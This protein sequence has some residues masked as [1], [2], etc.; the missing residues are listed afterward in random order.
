MTE[1]LIS[2]QGAS[3][4]STA[5]SRPPKNFLR[6]F[7]GVIFDPAKSFP[8]I[9]AI[10]SW[11]PILLVI[12]LLSGGFEQAYHS[13][14]I[15]M[16]IQ[17]LEARAGDNPQQMQGVMAFYQNAAITRPLFF[18]STALF[19]IVFLL[20]ITILSFF[21]C[22]VLF[23]GTARFKQVWVVSLWAYII[24]LVGMLVKTLLVIAKN[25][26]EAGLNFGLIFSENLVGPKLHGFFGA[27]DIFGIWH[28]IVM[29][30]G[31]AILY[32]FTIKKGI[33]ISFFI[34]LLMTLVG[35]V[36]AYVSA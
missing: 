7:F 9:I 21:V 14:V 1:E 16:S 35:G 13:Q 31:L 10:G 33:G 6:D 29:G 24:A 25:S 22:S 18:I 27:F 19:Q 3:G 34:W 36:S 23:G 17:K 32:K 20:I 15:N 12:I 28:F 5:L 26:V 4:D 8:N 2:E 30:I 11:V